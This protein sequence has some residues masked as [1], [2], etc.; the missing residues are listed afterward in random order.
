MI[1]ELFYV[2]ERDRLVVFFVTDET[3]EFFNG[4]ND[5]LLV[6]RNGFCRGGLF[7]TALRG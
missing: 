6:G 5:L 7:R 1:A 4:G 3:D 2:Y